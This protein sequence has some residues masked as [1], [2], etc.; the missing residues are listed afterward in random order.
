[1]Q[2]ES[3]F[4]IRGYHC[5]SYGHMNNAR[6]LE[7]FE[8]S[9]W[10]MLDQGDLVNQ[11]KRLGLLF[12]VVNI[13]VNYRRPIND[14]SEIVILTSVSDI[15]RKKMVIK[16]EIWSPDQQILFSD[17]SVNFVLFSEKEKRAFSIDENVKRLF[18]KFKHA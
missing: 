8:E 5:D 9:R 17:A 6:Y 14:G 16:Q 13:E 10:Q 3:H 15:G 2:I 1:M 7:L 12:F 4:K 11:M 18:E